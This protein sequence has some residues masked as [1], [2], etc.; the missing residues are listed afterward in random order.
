MLTGRFSRV[1]SPVGAVMATGSETGHHVACMPG[2]VTLCRTRARYEGQADPAPPPFHRLPPAFS[3][4][5]ARRAHCHRHHSQLH[6]ARA[7][8]L[9]HHHTQKLARSIACPH[10]TTSSL[11]VSR[12][13]KVEG[14]SPS[15][16]SVEQSSAM[17]TTIASSPPT[18]SFTLLSFW[19][20]FGIV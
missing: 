20:A 5:P 3:S 13:V 15:P 19:S 12:W 2:Q 6:R 10:S 17:A 4:S 8:E 18:S 7:R 14:E 11:R 16:I 9:P 1:Q